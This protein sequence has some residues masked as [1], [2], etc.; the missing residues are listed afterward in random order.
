[1]EFRI[2]GPLEVCD[3]GAR[4]ALNGSRQRRLLALLLLRRNCFVSVEELMETLWGEALPSSGSAA[5]HNLVSRL[6]RSLQPD[7]QNGAPHAI[8]SERAG[9]MLKVAEW[10]VDVARFEALVRQ[11]QELLAEN[12]PERAAEAVRV[13][14]ELWRGRPLG[15]LAYEPFAHSTVSALEDLRVGAIELSIEAELML[16][17]HREVVAQ[18]QELVAEHPLRERFRRQLMLALYRSSRQADALEVYRDGRDVLREELGLDPTA[19]LRSLEQA[20]LRHD[21]SLDVGDPRPRSQIAGAAAP[22]PLPPNSLVGRAREL[23]ELQSYL[24][25]PD[26]RLVTVCGPGGAGK[27][28]LALEVVHSLQGEFEDGTFFVSLGALSDATLVAPTIADALGVAGRPDETV[29]K[30][31]SDYLRPRKILLALD[32]FEHVLPAAALVSDILRTAGDV[33]VLATSR[34]P[35]RTLSEHRYYLRGLD[36]RDAVALFV[37]RSSAMNADFSGGE[38][39]PVLEEICLRLDGLPLALE[40]AAARARVLS[41]EAM[42]A[43]LERPLDLLT[44]GPR[45]LP[46]RQQ[47]LRTAI[48]WSVGFLEP[49]ERRLLT[50]LAVFRNG[51]T[52]DAASA[53]CDGQSAHG[54][55]RA[56][57]SLAEQSLLHVQ[58]SQG[59]EPRFQMF[60]TIRE[61]AREQLE[62]SGDLES[63]C[64]RHAEY[65]ATF[66]ERIDRELRRTQPIE[67]L[68]A[69]E[70]EHDN[71]RAAL[72]WSHGAS[73]DDLFVRLVCAQWFFLFTRG[74]WNE[75]GELVDDAL[76]RTREHP[77]RS[78]I[79]VLEAA[80][81]FAAYQGDL[82]RAK[83]FATEA[84]Q[85]SE[86][87]SDPRRLA[88]SLRALG[89]VALAEGDVGRA[90]TNWRRSLVLC[91]RAKDPEGVIDSLMK[92]SLLAQ[93]RGNYARA[94]VLLEEAAGLL[95]E[96]AA[97]RYRATLDNNLGYLAVV[98]GDYARAAELCKA[99][100]VF[101]RNVGDRDGVALGLLNLALAAL[102]EGRYA[103]AASL[104]DESLTL[105]LSLGH[106]HNVNYC[107]EAMA[108]V[109]AATQQN[110]LAARLLSGAQMHAITNSTPHDAADRTMNKT[111]IK[112]ARSHLGAES[113]ELERAQGRAMSIEALVD[114]A[115]Q[116]LHVL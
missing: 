35:L 98:E 107:L 89:H 36:L 29:V 58:P 43:R 86:S 76:E 20:I 4:L 93:E 101:F 27:S 55:E 84:L 8:V 77:D 73:S 112:L 90:N 99:S 108:A 104:L 69:L 44:D 106:R 6:R 42:L 85:L 1:V 94:R 52:I 23:R 15:D 11:A 115:R 102:G 38:K 59:G 92:M 50:Q 66:S 62:I 68:G 67:W 25:R 83:V 3:G 39:K 18:L 57:S 71:V 54:V 60:E 91:R 65:F 48:D 72:A 80:Y 111:T 87:I 19:D 12:R 47:T 5:L 63:T 53:V 9:Y 10:Q 116:L 16:G 37:A 95:P 88:R 41:P 30:T 64:L 14:L 82:Q 21:P 75:G 26:V 17:R 28:R 33:W 100:L 51:V 49:G 61:F 46:P 24:R 113:F 105:A 81:Y 40:L 13:A 22:V 32:D 114:D 110:A 2:L 7:H 79:D 70:A 97:P 56:L 74:Y 31:L 96:L 103:D 45:D 78:R 34:S 109:A